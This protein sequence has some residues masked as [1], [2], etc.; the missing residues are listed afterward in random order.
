MT[1]HKHSA[2]RHEAHEASE[3]EQRIRTRLNYTCLS[4]WRAYKLRQTA[5]STL[6]SSFINYLKSSDSEPTLNQDHIM[7]QDILRSASCLILQKQ[8]SRNELVRTTTTSNRY[9][10][11]LLSQARLLVKSN[12]TT[13]QPSS[14]LV[15]TRM[16]GSRRQLVSKSASAFEISIQI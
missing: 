13:K 12:R 8:T 5:V 14:A 3:E 11:K 6:I 2:D 9:P 16:N 15:Q 7:L 10:F 1:A 4:E